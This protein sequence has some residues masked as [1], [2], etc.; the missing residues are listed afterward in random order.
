MQENTIPKPRLARA[1]GNT[2]IFSLST[3]FVNV[4]LYLYQLLAGRVLSVEAYGILNGYIA[5]E[6]VLSIPMM[7]LGFFTVRYVSLAYERGGEV[8]SA[9]LS[10][11]L[12]RRMHRIFAVPYMLL[13]LASPLIARFFG[14]TS[15]LLVALAIA[16]AYAMVYLNFLRSIPYAKKQFLPFA[17]NSTIEIVVR[18]GVGIILGLLG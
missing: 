15:T 17:V 5:L 6:S 3:V 8:G 10:G 9:H 13:L 18:V 16:T 4:C 14:F 11:W 2:L 12:W 7:A 1:F